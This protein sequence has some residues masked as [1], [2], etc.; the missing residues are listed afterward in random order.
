MRKSMKMLAVLMIGCAALMDTGGKPV[1]AEGETI[2]S[3]FAIEAKYEE[4]TSFQNGV[5]FVKQ[6]GRWGLINTAGEFI[7]NPTYDEVHSFHEGRANV[8]LNG[9]WGFIDRSG[10]LIV[11]PRYE[12][13]TPEEFV[14]GYARVKRGGKYGFINLSGV[15][16]ILPS[17]W[18][19]SNFHN[20]V[21]VV[22]N[23]EGTYQFID[24]EGNILNETE[25]R[26]RTSFPFRPIESNQG[27]YWVSESG[28]E[29]DKWGVL[30][31]EGKVVIAPQ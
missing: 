7:V 28:E 21:A 11:E 25:Y 6:S 9:K 20:G 27:Y 1:N 31:W 16:V 19:A 15:E 17:Y 24:T 8:R 5:A 3:K 10:R 14:G 22:Q 26:F 29:G 2:G 12:N 30:D 13:E 18:Q 23:D 4:I